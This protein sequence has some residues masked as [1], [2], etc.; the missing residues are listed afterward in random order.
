MALKTFTT[1]DGSA[2]QALVT[3]GS[4]VL[5]FASAAAA[6]QVIQ[7][8]SN[9]TSG[10]F[11]TSSQTYVTTSQ[12]LSITPSSA[13][14][15]V[16]VLFDCSVSTLAANTGAA[17]E[18]RRAG[19]GIADIEM[20]TATVSGNLTTMGGT[21]VLD[22]PNTTSATTYEVFFK[23]TALAGTSVIGQRRLHL[24]EVKG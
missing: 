1:A 19:T 17:I 10:G 5:S 23:E 7:V 9:N 18:I 15:K 6:G 21:S 22:S 16:L 8:L 2:N 20:Y 4:G 13:S 3:N 11:S 24:L 12:S 14:N